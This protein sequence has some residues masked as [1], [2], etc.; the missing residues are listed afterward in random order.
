NVR[1][2]AQA[3]GINLPTVTPQRPATEKHFSKLTLRASGTSSMSQLG[4]FLYR[5]QTAQVPVAVNEIQVAT[6][7]DG[8][9]DLKV[10]LAI[11]T[12]YLTPEAARAAGAAPTPAPAREAE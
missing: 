3:S 1:E 7:K 2:W 10:D 5:I 12:I 4:K 8:T 9:D 6:R 11:E